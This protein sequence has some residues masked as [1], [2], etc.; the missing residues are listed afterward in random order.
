[1]NI[2]RKGK[3]LL[4]LNHLYRF[5]AN[6]LCSFLKV[7][8]AL[9]RNYKHIVCPRLAL[10]YQSLENLLGILTKNP[11]YLLPGCCS[12]L[13]IG[14]WRICHLL[15]LQHAHNVSFL[16]L[17]HFLNSF[18][19]LSLNCETLFSVLP[20]CILYSSIAGTLSLLVTRSGTKLMLRIR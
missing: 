16:F 19:V 1:M 9:H 8:F 5:L 4:L 13:S 15:L 10:C 12:I 6:R 14:M 7:K 3:Q 17:V 20:L 18:A 2:S 11:C